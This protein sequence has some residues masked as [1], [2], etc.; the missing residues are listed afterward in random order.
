MAKKKTKKAKKKTEVIEPNVKIAKSVPKVKGDKPENQVKD[1]TA[2]ST[3]TVFSGVMVGDK[4]IVEEDYEKALEYYNRG[5]F[6]EIHGVKKGRLELS[7][8][9]ALYLL[10]RGRIKVRKGS[11]KVLNFEEFVRAA[12]RSSKNFWTRYRAN[13]FLMPFTSPP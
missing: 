5:S 9:E 12:N 11:N 7:L 2:T 13:G 6:G 1:A 10:E 4:V 3:K 8:P